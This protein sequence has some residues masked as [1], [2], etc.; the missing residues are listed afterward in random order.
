VAG[1]LSV[2]EKLLREFGQSVF[3][4]VFRVPEVAGLYAS[5]VA[6]AEVDRQKGRIKGLRV[7]LRIEAPE[8]ALLPWEYLHDGGD[9]GWMGL[10]HR[11]PIIRFLD[12]GKPPQEL[13]VDGPLNVLGMIANP[14]GDWEPLDTERER[15]RI[16]EALKPLQQAGKV[17][18]CWVPGQTAEHLVDMISK[19]EWHVFHFIGHGGAFAASEGED[20][21]GTE[22]YIVLADEDSGAREVPASDLQFYLQGP[23]GQPRLVVLNCCESAREGTTRLTSPATTLVRAGI[24][25][26]VAM[27]FPISD[28]SA[29]KFAEAFYDALVT[30]KPIE[31]A[32]THARIKIQVRSRVEWGIPVLYTRS[33]SGRLFTGAAARL[34]VDV[35]PAP[36]IAPPVADAARSARTKLQQLFRT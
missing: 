5:S 21:G 22:G 16:D 8:L 23:Y 9:G 11:S 10:Q 33:R 36:V 1:P 2:Q 17:N 15:R 7:K 32:I 25:S 34:A 13:T 20:E 30:D 12:V 29:V 4:S 28:Q 18:F 26:V 6:M 14:G 35:V 27:Q 24:T 31:A 19:G 3:E